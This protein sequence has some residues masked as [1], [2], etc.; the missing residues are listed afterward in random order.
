MKYSSALMK[1]ALLTLGGALFAVAPAGGATITVEFG[2][3]PGVTP[4][5]KELHVE[6]GDLVREGAWKNATKRTTH[7]PT[8]KETFNFP[9]GTYLVR[10]FTGPAE[11]MSVARPGAF[12]TYPMYARLTNESS[13]QKFVFDTAR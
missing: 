11:E 4:D 1:A 3:A 6:I 13:A 7:E 10:V 12:Y 8:F 9:T 5:Y 2:P